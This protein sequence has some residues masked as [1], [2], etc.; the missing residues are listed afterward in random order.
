MRRRVKIAACCG[1]VRNGLSPAPPAAIAGISNAEVR[2][3]PSSIS[4]TWTNRVGYTD[5]VELRSWYFQPRGV[6]METFI[7]LDVSLQETSVCILNQRWERWFSRAKSHR[8]PK[9]SAV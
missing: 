4:P 2:E 7:G 6:T 3:N 8:N 9:L 5:W 1:S